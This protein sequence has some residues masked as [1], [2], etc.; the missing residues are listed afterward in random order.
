EKEKESSGLQ[1]EPPVSVTLEDESILSLDKN[2][3]QDSTHD[4]IRLSVE[5]ENASQG[6]PSDAL[7]LQKVEDRNLSFDALGLGLDSAITDQNSSSDALGLHMTP[8]EL[9]LQALSSESDLP[10][11]ID[12]A[13]TTEVEGPQEAL[14]SPSS[15]APSFIDSGPSQATSDSITDPVTDENGNEADISASFEV[16]TTTEEVKSTDGHELQSSVPELTESWT[17]IPQATE[18]KSALRK[19]AEILQVSPTTMGASA[20]DPIVIPSLSNENASI[21][22]LVK[23]PSIVISP[24]SPVSPK[25]PSGGIKKSAD[26]MVVGLWSHV[27]ESSENILPPKS[28]E[29][30]QR[31]RPLRKYLIT[32]KNVQNQQ[33]RIIQMSMRVI[34]EIPIE[35]IIKLSG[36]GPDGIKSLDMMPLPQETWAS[37]LHRL[38]LSDIKKV[39]ELYEWLERYIGAVPELLAREVPRAAGLLPPYPTEMENV[40]AIHVY[41]L[42][43][44]NAQNESGLDSNFVGVQVVEG[45]L[46][47]PQPRYY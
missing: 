40:L 20:T 43:E 11:I 44:K 15:H 2:R 19:A 35:G 1:E 41:R 28:A 17:V 13:S 9:E 38:S 37:Y 23:V 18:T 10:P 8:N 22:S 46:S 45:V 34:T 24:K 29:T 31:Q 25:S 7:G 27:S 4:S 26:H 21:H 16:S 12:L 33:K 36:Y 5:N 47:S 30:G 14:L 39:K 3:H 6:S 42:D 32:S